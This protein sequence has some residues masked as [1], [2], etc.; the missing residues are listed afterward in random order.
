MLLLRACV[1]T[2]IPSS[3]QTFAQDTAPTCTVHPPPQQSS[4]ISFVC[5]KFDSRSLGKYEL[6]LCDIPSSRPS[7]CRASKQL[8]W[9]GAWW[10]GGPPTKKKTRVRAIY[11]NARAA[12]VCS[13]SESMRQQ[14]HK[15]R[16]RQQ[17]Y[18]KNINKNIFSRAHR[19]LESSLS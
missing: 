17:F 13:H 10:T 4:R 11:Q 16:F 15:R 3:L 6:S 19:S 18:V 2:S 7:F 5:S 1:H 9:S 14:Q 12:V 8:F